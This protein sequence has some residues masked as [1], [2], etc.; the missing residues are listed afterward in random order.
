MGE[1][2]AQ[3]I[4]RNERTLLRHMLAEHLPQRLM[5]KM[6]GR[7]VGADLRAPLVVDIELEREA[8]GDLALFDDALVN[9]DVAELL[10]GVFDAK[11]HAAGAHHAD[12]ADLSARL[13]RRTGSD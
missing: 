1:I 12:V 7:M 4:R 8:G 6:R 9:E 13:R 10:D 2:E 3:P 5:Q 11:A